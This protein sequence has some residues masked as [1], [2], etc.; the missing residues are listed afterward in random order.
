MVIMKL[1]YIQKSFPYTERRNQQMRRI[2]RTIFPSRFTRKGSQRY[3]SVPSSVEERMGLKDGD[4]LDVE[5]SWP[6]TEEYD[7]ENEK[8]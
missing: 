8:Q 4:Y 5:I 1:F 3:I 7:E 6:E 2:A